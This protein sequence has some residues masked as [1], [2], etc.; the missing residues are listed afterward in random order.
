MKG[1]TR[2]GVAMDDELLR[3][4]DR[5]LRARGYP[6]RSE[7]IRD[8]VR[9]RLVQ[10]LV[11]QGNQTVVGTI[12][13]VYNHDTRELTER[14]NHLQHD[15]HEAIVCTSHVHLDAH[16]CVEVLIVRGRAADVTRIA[17]RLIGT[18]GVKHGKLGLTVSG[19]EL[20]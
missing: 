4:F 11:Q 18:K 5:H 7:A 20:A 17:D 19:K 2:F 16:N 6:N 14:L 13:L 10:E 9:D 8:L 3:R 12:T 1:L 15:Y